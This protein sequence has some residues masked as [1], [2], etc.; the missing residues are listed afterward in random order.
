V[1]VRDT[2]L[3]L[4]GEVPT[5]DLN[6]QY[7]AQNTEASALGAAGLSMAGKVE[8]AGREL[9]KKMAR[10]DPYLMKDRAQYC[11]FHALSECQR[12][13]KCP[14]KHELPKEDTEGN[15]EFL[16]RSDELQDPK[17]VH[18]VRK[19]RYLAGLVPPVDQSITSLFLTGL[20]D[21][22]DE[23]DIRDQMYAYGEIKSVV[24]A[25][26]SQ[27]AFVNYVTRAAAEL[28]AEAC[29]SGL[30]VRDVRLKVAWGK[31]RP[32]GPNEDR[33]KGENGNIGEMVAPLPPGAARVK[34]PSQ[35]PT[36][37]GAAKR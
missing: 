30:M 1:D 17:T 36:L 33:N 13:D 12:G 5:S 28:A 9:L 3:Q 34:Y 35:D 19:T 14:Y 20:N 18:L 22:I 29:H 8:S 27:C 23:Q 25:R 10:K 4:E 24:V 15:R 7:F 31:A 2:A 11:T 21:N 32:L 26:K 16:E 37:L 6:R